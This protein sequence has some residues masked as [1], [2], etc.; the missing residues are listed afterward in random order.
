MWIMPLQ[1]TQAWENGANIA[2]QLVKDEPIQV[3][4]ELAG[5][6]IRD[7]LAEECAAPSAEDAGEGSAGEPAP[8]KPAKPGKTKPAA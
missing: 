4:D 6:L 5:I 2:T 3:S 8:A 1:T 7:E